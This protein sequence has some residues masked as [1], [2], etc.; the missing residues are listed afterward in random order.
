[1]SMN[2]RIEIVLLV[3]LT[4]TLGILVTARFC[5]E[6]WL[7]QTV[8]LQ[9]PSGFSVA[10]AFACA[11]VLAGRIFDRAGQVEHGGVLIG[12]DLP[13][14]R[15]ARSL[16]AATGRLERLEQIADTEQIEERPVLDAKRPEA[17]VDYA[18]IAT[19]VAAASTH[20]LGVRFA[21]TLR[22]A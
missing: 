1:M 16:R 18:C 3:L 6:A 13:P 4:V 22:G 9:R 8:G 12:Q 5:D 11:L 21:S 19:R 7:I 10:G 14:C 17:G 2:S 15:V 20:R